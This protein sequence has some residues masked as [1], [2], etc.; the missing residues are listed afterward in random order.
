MAGYQLLVVDVP[1]DG[2]YDST[3]ISLAAVLADH[4][5]PHTW[6]IELAYAKQLRNR[7]EAAVAQKPGDSTFIDVLSSESS[8]DWR[9]GEGE[10]RVLFFGGNCTSIPEQLWLSPS[11]LDVL[12]IPSDTPQQRHPGRR[13]IDTIPHIHASDL[14]DR[15][16]A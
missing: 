14:L 9:G 15:L 1:N 11:Q 4:V 12:V 5:Q 3:C 7:L 10:T 2:R 8:D 13:F 16:T 6:V